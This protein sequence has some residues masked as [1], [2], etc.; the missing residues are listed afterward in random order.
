[1]SDYIKENI[2]Y[3]KALDKTSSSSSFNGTRR[4]ST[5]QCPSIPVATGLDI[6][7]TTLIRTRHM[8]Q[9]SSRVRLV[10]ASLIWNVF[11]KE[12]RGS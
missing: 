3:K 1:M 2:F 8:A 5:S 6:L 4:K 9:S 7:D 12:R 11:I 10:E